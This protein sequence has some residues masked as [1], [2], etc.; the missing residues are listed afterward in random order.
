MYF[1]YILKSLRTGRYYVGSTQNLEERLRK[2]NAGHSSATKA[3]RPWKLMHTE[4]FDTR[5]EALCREYQIKRQ[6]SRAYIEAL[7]V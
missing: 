4:V 6:K 7:F 5:R 1:V 2:H 3:Y